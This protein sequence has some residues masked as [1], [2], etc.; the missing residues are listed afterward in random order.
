MQ[1]LSEKVLVLNKNFYVLCVVNAKSAL[2]LVFGDKALIMDKEYMSYTADEWREVAD[3][4]GKTLIRTPTKAFVV[5]EVIRLV[6]FDQIINRPVNLTRQNVFIR[7]EFTCQYCNR[8]EKLTIDHIIP[9]SRAEEFNMTMKEI[10]AWENI[11]TCCEKCNNKK[12]N[13]T[14]TEIG[15]KL[16]NK[17]YRPKTSSLSFERKHLKASWK[18]YLKGKIEIQEDKE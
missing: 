3:P 7:D 1:V 2:R 8:S 11:T 16:A 13:K 15:W 12:D 4:E 6:D 9:K 10:N 18:V 14:L 5:P 17:P